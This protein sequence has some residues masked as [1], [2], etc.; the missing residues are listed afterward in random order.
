VGVRSEA[1]RRV[2]I[3]EHFRL[4][5]S[6]KLG[7]ALGIGALAVTIGS[8]LVAS[9]IFVGRMDFEQAYAVPVSASP[10]TRGRAVT[11]EGAPIDD[12]PSWLEITLGLFGIACIVGGGAGAMFSLR[13]VLMEESYLAL[14]TDGALYQT[15]AERSFV[16]WDDVEEVRWD[17]AAVQ[18]VRH[19]GSAW[20]RNERYAGIDGARLAKRAADVRRRALFGLI[21]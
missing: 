17:G 6:K 1:E 18:F 13:R 14:R 8:I 19:D 10:I 5:A 12:A 9:S 3:V 21:K 20:A 15:D 2:P 16:A 4:D 7:R 11:S